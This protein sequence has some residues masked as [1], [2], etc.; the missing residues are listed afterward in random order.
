M[1]FDPVPLCLI[2]NAWIRNGTPRRFESLG[3]LIPTHRAILF[4]DWLPQAFPQFTIAIDCN[5]KRQLERLAG[6]SDVFGRSAAVILPG[7]RIIAVFSPD[8]SLIFTW[9]V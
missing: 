2:H 1:C 4:D 7:R 3:N 5:Q 8:F 6:R 9:S